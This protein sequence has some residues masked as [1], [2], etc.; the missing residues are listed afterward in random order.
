MTSDWELTIAGGRL[1]LASSENMNVREGERTKMEER[2]GISQI[3]M[4]L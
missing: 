2:D 4:K 3:S 1:D